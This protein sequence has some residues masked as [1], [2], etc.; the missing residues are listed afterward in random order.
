MDRETYQKTYK[1]ILE[2][3]KEIRFLKLDEFVDAIN[4]AQAV[5]PMAD[6]TMYRASMKNME[7]LKKM[8]QGLID[9]Q[10][11]LPENREIIDGAIDAHH[12]KETHKGL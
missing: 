7:M 10:N 8:A 5:G 6:P 9:F 1:K 11:S 3:A 4:M 2:A 12:Y